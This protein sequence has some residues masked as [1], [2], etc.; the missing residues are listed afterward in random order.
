MENTEQLGLGGT[1]GSPSQIYLMHMLRLN[2]KFFEAAISLKQDAIEAGIASLIASVPADDVR[3]SLWAEYIGTRDTLRN[4]GN[5]GC[6]L[7]AAVLVLGKISTWLAEN[8]EILKFA[9]A[10]VL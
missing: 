8:L 1:D 5:G 7:S 4:A 3:K 10:G 9:N 2:T 6:T